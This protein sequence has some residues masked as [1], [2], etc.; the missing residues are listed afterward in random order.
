MPKSIGT[1]NVA[2]SNNYY[3]FINPN[4][5]ANCKIWQNTEFRNLIDTAWK[6]VHKVVKL[7][8]PV[9]FVRMFREVIFNVILMFDGWGISWTFALSWEA[10]VLTDDTSTLVQL[11]DWGPRQQV[12]TLAIIDPDII[13]PKEPQSHIEFSR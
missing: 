2:C 5:L 7:V 9:G 12:V 11:I 13:R 1:E 6:I 8:V 3:D 4:V 10:L